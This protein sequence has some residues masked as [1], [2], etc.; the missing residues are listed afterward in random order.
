M[1]EACKSMQNYLVATLHDWNIN[2]FNERVKSWPGQWHL[3]TDKK[4]LT[5]DKLQ[6]LKPRYVFFPHWSWIVPSDII[7]NFE[8]V[9]F[10]MTDLPYGRGGSPLQNLIVR[11]HKETQISALR[12]TEDLDAGPVYMKR[13]LSLEGPAHEIYTRASQVIFDMIEQF[14]SDEP[15]AQ[16]QTGEVTHF[17]RRSPDMSRIPEKST[18]AQIYDYIRML[19]A[20]GYP[21]A[22][23]DF[24]GYR[25]YFSEAEL[26]ED[27]EVLAK[28]RIEKREE[29][30]D[31][32]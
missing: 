19:D 11:G 15:Q 28:V 17:E 2:L 27:Q 12:M 25:L 7:Q 4:D 29:G 5:Y 14:V 30:F 21:P 26:N 23:L 24:D 16:P 8:C 10:H 20:P 1:K 32:G 3:I 31:A 13:P 22:F 18:S 6:A 9:C